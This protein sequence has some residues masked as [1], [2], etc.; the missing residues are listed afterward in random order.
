MGF[1]SLLFFSATDGTTGYEP[2]KSDGTAAGTVRVADI[3]PGAGDS[4]PSYPWAFVIN[5]NG[6]AF[7][8][9]H[10]GTHGDEPWESDGTQAGTVLVKDIFPGSPSALDYWPNFT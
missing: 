9:A 5:V 8:P 1:G 2:W 7:F 10:D 4:Y 3:N 6:T